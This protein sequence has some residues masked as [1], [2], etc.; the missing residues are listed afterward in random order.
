MRH[1][2]ELAID[3]DIINTVVFNGEFTPGNQWS[4]PKS[5]LHHDVSD[6]EAQHRDGARPHQGNRRSNAITIDTMVPNNAALLQVGEVIQA[7]AAEAGFDLKLR[8]TEFATSLTEGTKGNF[9]LYLIGWSGR[10]DPDQ[11]VINHLGCD[12]PFNWGKYCSE[13]VMKELNAGRSETTPEKRKAAYERALTLIEHDKPLI[14]LYHPTLLFAHTASLEGYRQ[15]WDETHPAAR[16]EAGPL[17]WLA[18]IARRLG[19]GTDKMRSPSNRDD[20]AT[21]ACVGFSILARDVGRR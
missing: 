17:N 18:S 9:Q 15:P 4:N 13:A 7:M 10:T 3:R 5:V 1:A 20:A 14:Y 11:N 2:L 16:H 21:D 19:H 6:S 12:T 8:A